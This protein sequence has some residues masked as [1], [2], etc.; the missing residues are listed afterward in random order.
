MGFSR[1]A[2]GALVIAS[3]ARYGPIPLRLALV[4]RSAGSVLRAL[5]KLGGGGAF[6]LCA[7]DFW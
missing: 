2:R 3:K 1:C 7:R 4:G 6:A 5:R